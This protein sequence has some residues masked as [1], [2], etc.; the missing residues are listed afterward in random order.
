MKKLFLT[1]AIVAMTMLTSCKKS[2]ADLIKDYDSVCKELVEATKNG[3]FAKVAT[4]SEKG[5]KLE[6]EL[7]GREL[8][9]EE[10][11]QFQEIQSKVV[12]GIVSGAADGISNMIESAGEAAEQVAG[13][14]KNS[15]EKIQK[16]FDDLDDSDDAE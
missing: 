15:A 12:S 3:D 10:K 13:A 8:T 14:A 1:V 11:L 2:N 6:N 4:L 7:S 5:Q 16:A 9:D